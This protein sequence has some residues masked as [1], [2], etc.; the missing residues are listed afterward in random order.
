MVIQTPDD[1]TFSLNDIS[2]ELD[3]SSDEDD[4][5]RPGYWRHDAPYMRLPENVRAAIELSRER[6]KH[7]EFYYKLR[8]LNERIKIYKNHFYHKVPYYQRAH[9]KQM[10]HRQKL[11]SLGST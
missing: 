1:N 5:T 6:S 4:K 10:E 7:S 8:G 3:D 2:S 11:A 9:M